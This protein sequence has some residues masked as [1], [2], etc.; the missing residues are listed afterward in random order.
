MPINKEVV[1]DF[2]VHPYR[3]TLHS[4]FKKGPLLGTDLK[5]A[6]E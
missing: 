3:D 6:L 2:R 1:K 4:Y 5:R